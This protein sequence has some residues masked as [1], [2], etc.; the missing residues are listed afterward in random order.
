MVWKAKLHDFEEQNLSNLNKMDSIS[1]PRIRSREK[2]M[3]FSETS[4]EKDLDLG[5][6]FIVISPLMPKLHYSSGLPRYESCGI[7]AAE[8]MVAKMFWPMSAAF[9]QSQSPSPQ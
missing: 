6:P 5:N 2:K 7:W 1:I 4:A 8:K 3:A 9:N